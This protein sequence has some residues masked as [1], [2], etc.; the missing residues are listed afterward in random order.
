MNDAAKKDLKGY[1]KK[2]LWSAT[3]LLVALGVA[4]LCTYLAQAVDFYEPL[5]GALIGV[6][7]ATLNLFAIGYAFFVVV[8][9]EGK[10]LA[11]F[12]PILSFTGMCAMAFLLAKLWPTL[13]FGF[14]VGLTAPVLFGIILR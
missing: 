4:W 13:I 8:I 5:L 7:C 6:A 3:I 14:A 10:K 9:R 1:I 12:A 2:T 11:V